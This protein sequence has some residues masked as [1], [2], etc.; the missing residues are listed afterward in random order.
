MIIA[1]YFGLLT[2]ISAGQIGTSTIHGSNECF[3]DDLAPFS[4]TLEQISPE[5]M[6]HE[7][8]GPEHTCPVQI[9]FWVNGLQK[10]ALRQ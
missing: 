1:L 10:Y 8:L 5:P 7:Q 4:S 2:S 6:V 3:L 9:G